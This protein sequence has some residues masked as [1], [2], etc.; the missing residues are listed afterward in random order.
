MPSAAERFRQRDREA[1]FLRGERPGDLLPVLK[2][3]SN[4][5][6]R[7]GTD[8][9]PSVSGQYRRASRLGGEEGMG[10]QLARPSQD[11]TVIGEDL[12]RGAHDGPD[13]LRHR[14]VDAKPFER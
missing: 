7:P 9:G 14:R 4:L 12:A 5:G 6:S 10:S 3:C 8:L 1:F 2:V 13:G 11:E